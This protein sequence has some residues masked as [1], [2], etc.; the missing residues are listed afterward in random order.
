MVQVLKNSVR[1]RI[2]A[3]AEH[4]FAEVGYKKATVG[5]IAGKAGVATGNIYKYYANKETLFNSIITPEFV[6][7]FKT[8]TQ[9]RVAT[10]IDPAKSEEGRS[11][12]TGDAGRLLRFWIENRLKVIIILSKAE[13]SK[14]E[15]FV[16]E[17]IQAMTKQS[18]DNLPTAYPTLKDTDV[19]R[20]T[21]NIRIA[22]TVKGVVSILETFEDEQ[23]IVDAFAT[24]WAYHYAGI[25]AVIEWCS[26]LVDEKE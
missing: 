5:M 11:I 21:F 14:Y 3:A 19:F 12:E 7:E 1:N 22:D 10:L 25:N 8:L 17:Y 15:S 23:Q 9:N 24:S 6:E 4:M 13:G 16:E 2:A 20:F 18:M 26:R